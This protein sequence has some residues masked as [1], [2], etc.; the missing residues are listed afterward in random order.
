M[1]I[2]LKT[3]LM[4]PL[5]QACYCKFSPRLPPLEAFLCTLISRPLSRGDERN[6]KQRL[7]AGDSP[8]C[9]CLRRLFQAV[10]QI[11]RADGISV[12]ELRL[13]GQISDRAE[14]AP[15]CEA[16]GA[17]QGIR[18]PH[19]PFP[20]QSELAIRIRLPNESGANV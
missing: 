8:R 1:A 9:E 6:G 4:P 14:R 12:D 15:V 18:F 2:S 3:A 7:H 16:A 5:K 17:L 10:E 13:D 11:R 19:H 20:L